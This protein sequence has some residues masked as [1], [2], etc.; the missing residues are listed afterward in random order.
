M[1]QVGIS[2]GFLL[3]TTILSWANCTIKCNVYEAITIIVSFISI[4]LKEVMSKCIF[5]APTIAKT[6]SSKMT[7]F[8]FYEFVL[9][10]LCVISCQNLTLRRQL[11]IFYKRSKQSEKINVYFSRLRE[12]TLIVIQ[13]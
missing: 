7:I 12:C 3:D 11:V 8:P 13:V 2:F 9:V 5:F 1:L 4:K 6:Y 10:R